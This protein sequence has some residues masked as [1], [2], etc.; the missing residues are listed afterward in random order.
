MHFKIKSK[1]KGLSSL[2]RIE[3]TAKDPSA[4][5]EERFAVTGPSG[6]SNE[7][8]GSPITEGSLLAGKG[9]TKYVSFFYIACSLITYKNL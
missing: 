7:L 4:M 9:M 2:P 3:P 8:F 1:R 6:K 5:T